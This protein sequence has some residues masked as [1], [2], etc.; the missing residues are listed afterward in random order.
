MTD[1]AEYIVD[2]MVSTYREE[3]DGY[4]DLDDDTIYGDVAAVALDNLQT[5]LVST[6]RGAALDPTALERFRV[7]A[8]RRVHQGVSLDALLHAYVMGCR[9]IWD[10]CQRIA[11]RPTAA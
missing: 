3:I 10:C 9:V 7:S 11:A 1:R 2:E 4:R 6:E 5:V 8:A